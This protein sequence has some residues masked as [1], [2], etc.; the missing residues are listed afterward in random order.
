MLHSLKRKRRGKVGP[1]ALKLDI[2]NAYDRIEW[3]FLADMMVSL[4]F[5]SK[6]VELLL[7]CIKSVS[8]SEVL[9]GAKGGEFKPTQGLR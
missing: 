1:F 2:S 7:R 5:C 9:S 3:S 8:Y 4:G 6:W